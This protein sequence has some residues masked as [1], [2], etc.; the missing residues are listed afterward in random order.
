MQGQ[1]AIHKQFTEVVSFKTVQHLPTKIDAQ[2]LAD[3]GVLVSVL[4][5]L[6]VR[7]ATVPY[8]ARIRALNTASGTH[9]HTRFRPC[10]TVVSFSLAACVTSGQ[11]TC[12]HTDHEEQTANK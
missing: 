5:Q 2:P 4:G 7:R 12:T 8:D 9:V 10:N 3:G 6:Q 11:N 1:E